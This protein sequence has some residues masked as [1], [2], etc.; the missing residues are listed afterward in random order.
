MAI[1]LFAGAKTILAASDSPNLNGTTW[2]PLRVGAGGWLTGICIAP[3]GRMLVR[4]DTYG[5]YIW[6]GTQWQQLVTATSMPT[7]FT[8][9]DVNEGVYEIQIAPSNTNFLYMVYDGYV[10]Q[11]TNK[12]TTWTQTSFARVTEDPNDP[13]R[14]YGQKAAVDPHNPNL[15][16]V[17]TPQNGLFVTTNGGATWQSVTGVPVSLKD[18]KGLYP[19]ITGIMFDPAVGGASEERTNTIFASSYGNGVYESTDAGASWTRLT[20][21]PS[22]VENAAVSSTG[23]YYA[24]GDGNTD[25]WSYANDKWTELLTP[26]VVGKNGIQAVAI[27]P[28]NPSEIVVI[29]PGGSL[30][31]SYDGGTTWSGNNWAARLRSTD[32]PWL[33]N[34]GPY[35]SI[36]G[37]EFSPSV[38]TS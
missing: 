22:N 7:A 15:V 26:S 36:G 33:A 1:L 21:G 37:M 9:V 28:F 32:V 10:F 34:T 27:D 6:N 38:E 24:V 4:A 12:G 31:I 25:L 11:S 13:Y 14:M 3:D 5:G 8:R 23:V 2:H 19:G 35:M 17:G 30:N 16:Y 18:A 29:T 20:G